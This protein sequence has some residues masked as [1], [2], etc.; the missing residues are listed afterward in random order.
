M[1]GTTGREHGK[2]PGRRR[3]G[4]PGATGLS[5]KRSTRGLDGRGKGGAGGRPRRRRRRQARAVPR[6]LAVRG[7]LGVDHRRHAAPSRGHENDNRGEGSPPSMQDREP[8]IAD[9]RVGGRAARRRPPQQQPAGAIAAPTL[10][11]ECAMIGAAVP[12]PPLRLRFRPIR[13][14]ARLQ[15][16]PLQGAVRPCVGRHGGSKASMERAMLGI[17]VSGRVRH[18]QARAC[19]WDDLSSCHH[20]T[21]SDPPLTRRWSGHGIDIGGGA[22]HSHGQHHDR[23]CRGD[24]LH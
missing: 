3:A 12:C 16:L 8:G 21:R 2:C 22:G 14:A 9:R 5:I 1:P 11:A 19:G 23:G 10:A 20:G 15:G 24:R 4:G 7:R 13:R 6:L 17:W 18:A